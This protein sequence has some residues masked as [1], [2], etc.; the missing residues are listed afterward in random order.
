LRSE[1]K[2]PPPPPPHH[3]NDPTPVKMKKEFVKMNKKLT[4]DKLKNLNIQCIPLTPQSSTTP[5]SRN[6]QIKELR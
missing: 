3:S 6:P 2:P 5:V 1:D 4:H